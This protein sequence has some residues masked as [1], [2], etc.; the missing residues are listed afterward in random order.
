MNDSREPARIEYGLYRASDAEEMTKLLADAFT[1]HDPLAW[2]VGV[3]PTDFASLVVSLLPQVAQEDLTIVAR[4]AATG[5]M[6]GALLTNDP[7]RETAASMET[8]SDRFAPIGSILGELVTT[9]RAGREPRE[10]EMLH[11]Y[12]LGVS[13]RAAGNGVGKRLVAASVENGSRKDYRVAVA[14]ATN[15]KS[16]HIFRT[17]G[18][19]ERGQILFKEHVFRG[20]KVFE[21]IAEYGGPILMEKVLSGADS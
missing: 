4:L 21:H 5:E 7:A 17:Q 13:D 6:A 11:L 20:R 2:A 18:F 14:E 1:R 3:E 10:G 12:F 19:A 9:Y 16:Q 15:P 8:L